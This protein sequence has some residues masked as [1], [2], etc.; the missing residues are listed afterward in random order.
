MLAH[1]PPNS[2]GYSN[3]LSFLKRQRRYSEKLFAYLRCH[4][5]ILR[6]DFGHVSEVLRS[7]NGTIKNKCLTVSFHKGH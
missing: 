6:T 5:F 4:G 1:E 2:R 7:L 3:L